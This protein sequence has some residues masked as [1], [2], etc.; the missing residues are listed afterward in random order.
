[1]IGCLQHTEGIKRAVE[2]GL[3]VG[4]LSTLTLQEAFARGTLV[5]LPVPHRNWT[6]QFYFIVHRDKFRSQGIQDWIALCRKSSGSVE[7]VESSEI[8][9]GTN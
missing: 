2:A 8:E 3:G 4:C 1:M 5:P 7:S 6:R 9:K